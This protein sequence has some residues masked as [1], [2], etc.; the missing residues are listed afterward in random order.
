M[1]SISVVVKG[2][3]CV[4]NYGS[5]VVVELWRGE[6]RPSWDTREIGVGDDLI[7]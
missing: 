7:K 5:G 3:E 2:V 1:T 6:T 4:S